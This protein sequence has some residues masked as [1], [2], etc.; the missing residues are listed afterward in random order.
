MSDS[1]ELEIE[2]EKKL[3]D[4]QSTIDS[5]AQTLSDSDTND[6]DKNEILS[7]INKAKAKINNIVADIQS[8][9][10]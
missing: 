2:Y 4:L 5:I 10:E 3:K 7:H 1:N 8:E 9:E 6:E